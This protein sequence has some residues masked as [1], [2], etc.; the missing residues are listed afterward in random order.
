MADNKKEKGPIDLVHQNAIH[1]ETILKEHRCQKLYTKFSINPYKKCKF[2]LNST[3]GLLRYS[4]TSVI[5]QRP[6]QEQ[7]ASIIL[8]NVN[9]NL[10]CSTF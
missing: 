7:C 4:F 10:K 3:N 5:N 9:N 1:V 2:A 8:V 6:L